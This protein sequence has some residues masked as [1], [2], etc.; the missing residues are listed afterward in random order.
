MK[1]QFTGES[2]QK[3]ENQEEAAPKKKKCQAQLTKNRRE[4][5]KH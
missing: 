2:T 3:Y 1:F 5:G 4:R